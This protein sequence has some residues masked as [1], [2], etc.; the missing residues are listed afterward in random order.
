MKTP[1]DMTRRAR[2]VNDGDTLHR[3]D[4]IRFGRAVVMHKRQ[5][6]F[7]H[8][9]VYR[10]FCMQLRVDRLD[11][12]RAISGGSGGWLFGV[13]RSRA[14][15]FKSADHGDR[16]GGDLMGWL[17][18]TLDAVALKHPGGATWLQCFPRMF[19]Y[20]FNPVSFWMMHD[21]DGNL[22]I[23]LAE[24]NNTFGQ[25][26]QY[27]LQAPGGGVIGQADELVCHKVFHVSPFCEI[28]GHYRFRYQ[29]QIGAAMQPA[30]TTRGAGASVMRQSM[31]IDFYD[32]ASSELAL[33][34][35]AITVEPRPWTT[36]RL[37]GALVRMPWMTFGVMVRIHWHALKLWRKGAP[38]F[39]VPATPAQEATRNAP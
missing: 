22:R 34:R 5:K 16:T 30:Q 13:D 11:Q 25:R 28:K 20:V 38:F 37:L 31:A 18:Q 23:I 7:T 6:P 26:H 19:G 36:R 29:G 14:V 15:S 33:L 12:V 35:T 2:S 21:T 4:L 8:A 27:V 10:L 39:R 24:V 1:D 9:F 32:D 17:H 3:D